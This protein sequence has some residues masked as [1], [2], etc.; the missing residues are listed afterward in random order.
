MPSSVAFERQLA[1]QWSSSWTGWLEPEKDPQISQIVLKA[2]VYYL[3][4]LW[5]GSDARHTSGARHTFGGV[6]QTSVGFSA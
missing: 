5:T 6:D 2:P 3:C 4:N 1:A